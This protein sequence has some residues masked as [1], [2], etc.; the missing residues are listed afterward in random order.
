MC[1][2]CPPFVAKEIDVRDQDSTFVVNIGPTG[3]DRGYMS[4]AGI[5]IMTY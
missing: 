3:L 4:I 5:I 2:D 1:P